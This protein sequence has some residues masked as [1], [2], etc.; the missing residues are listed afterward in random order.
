VTVRLPAG[1]WVMSIRRA[2]AFGD[3]GMV[4]CRTPSE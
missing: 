3:A 1:A 4:T 2:C